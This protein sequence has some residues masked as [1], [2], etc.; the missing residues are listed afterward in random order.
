MLN[1]FLHS[2]MD[3]EQQKIVIHVNLY[4]RI[5]QK[6]P[7]HRTARQLVFEWLN[8]LQNFRIKE[9]DYKM[10]FASFAN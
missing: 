5:P 4:R 8:F 7:F 9:V 2:K 1:P 10:G 6:K 3:F